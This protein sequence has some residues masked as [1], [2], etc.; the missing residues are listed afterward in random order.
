MGKITK[1]TQSEGGGKTT[2]YPI[3]IPQAIVDPDSMKT[4]REELDAQRI[5][6]LLLDTNKGTIGWSSSPNYDITGI[7]YDNEGEKYA[8]FTRNEVA[9]DWETFLY[10]LRPEVIEA[11]KTYTLS[12]K[13]RQ[14]EHGTATNV[15]GAALKAGIMTQSGTDVLSSLVDERN[16]NVSKL[17][18]WVQ[19]EFTI[20]SSASGSVGGSQVI[21]IKTATTNQLSWFEIKDLCLVEGYSSLGWLPAQEEIKRTTT[22]IDNGTSNVSVSVLLADIYYKWGVISALTISTLE[23]NLVSTAL[24]EYMFQFTAS[25]SGCTLTLPSGIK[26]LNG[27]TPVI[28]GGKT[29]QVSIVNNLAVCGV[30]E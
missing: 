28:E 25:S 19:M 10:K 30:F 2:A 8:S 26:W 29:Y 21:Y 27:E 18:E 24:H 4:L 11:N 23:A 15:E 6:N 3:T 9:R 22:V 20:V 14:L 1:L 16:G 5:G 7:R 12:F 13:I 17:N